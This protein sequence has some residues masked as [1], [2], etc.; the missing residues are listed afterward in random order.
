MIVEVVRHWGRPRDLFRFKSLSLAHG[1]TTLQ[2]A[3]RR[4][5]DLQ[6]HEH[7][8]R[9]LRYYRGV[10]KTRD[11]RSRSTPV[12]QPSYLRGRERRPRLVPSRSGLSI[13]VLAFS[14]ISKEDYITRIP[15]APQRIKLHFWDHDAQVLHEHGFR[16]T[17]Q[18]LQ[19]PFKPEKREEF[20]E[21]LSQF[22]DEMPISARHIGYSQAGTQPTL[23]AARESL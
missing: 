12:R 11:E 6:L 7:S 13:F 14:L 1:P 23:C 15:L 19:F 17:K 8:G 3:R 10:R 22:V 18:K 21:A 9:G 5:A 2:H 20:L 16:Q 4:F